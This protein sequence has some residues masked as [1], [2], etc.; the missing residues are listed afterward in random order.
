MSKKCTLTRTQRPHRNHFRFWEQELFAQMRRNTKSPNP[1]LYA[2]PLSHDYQKL[3]SMGE[4]DGLDLEDAKKLQEAADAIVAQT[5][6]DF[7]KNF[8]NEER[9]NGRLMFKRV[10]ELSEDADYAE[11]YRRAKINEKERHS[12]GVLRDAVLFLCYLD[13]TD[14][15]PDMASSSDSLIC[16]SLLYFSVGIF[17]MGLWQALG[18]LVGFEKLVYLKSLLQY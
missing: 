13:M 14:S 8:S 11:A 6:E 5:R 9:A 4:F 12:C 3:S 1:H 16:Y 2:L 10:R 15:Y 18:F 7:V 17:S